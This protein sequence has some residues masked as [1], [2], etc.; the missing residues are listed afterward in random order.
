MLLLYRHPNYKLFLLLLFLT[1]EET[2]RVKVMYLLD[3]LQQL[4]DI[5]SYYILLLTF[6]LF[7]T[8]LFLSLI[9]M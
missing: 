9:T 3:K 7:I 4:L 8:S 2:D 1:I 6:I 5:L